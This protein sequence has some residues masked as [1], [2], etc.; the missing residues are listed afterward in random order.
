MHLFQCL[1]E[2]LLPV[3][4]EVRVDIHGG[5]NVFVPDALRDGDCREALIDE[6]GDMGVPLRYN[7]D[8][9]KKPLFSR[10]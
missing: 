5:G 2:H 9:R 8:K 6:Q 10:G 4:K 3:R 7:N 1:H